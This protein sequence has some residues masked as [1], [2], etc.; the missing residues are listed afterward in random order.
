MRLRFILGDQ[1]NYNHSWLNDKCD[2]V[3]YFMCEMH[4]ETNY[5]T[6]H[7]QKVIGFFASM[8]S[9]AQFLT[10]KQHRVIYQELD[11]INSK[12]PLEEILND[13][14]TQHQITQFE[15]QFPDEYRLDQQFSNFC[16]SLNIPY[17]AYDTE[18]FY[19][20]RE[21]LT[22]FFEGKK[23]FTMEFFYR[24][25]R[26]K[27][28]VMMNDAKNPEGG[29]WNFDG[30]NRKKWTGKHIIPPNITFSKEISEIN[31]LL[32]SQGIK[33][34][35]SVNEKQF[36]WP[37]NRTESLKTLHYFCEHLLVHFGDYQD[38]MHSD[39]YYLF[40]SNLSFAMNT[41]M[42]SPKEIVDTVVSYWRAHE[43]EI[44]ISQ[45]EGFVRQIIGWREYMRGIYWMQMPTYTTLN[46]LENPNPLPS[47]YWTGKTKMNCLRSCIN[48]S[49]QTGYAHH[50]QRLMVTGN[51][52]LLTQS[53]PDQVDAW[54]LGIYSDALEW[55]QLPNTR[56]MSQYADGGIVATKPYISSGSYINK[57]SNYCKGC[58]YKVN[59]KTGEK[60]CPFNSLYWNFLH[61]KRDLL[62]NNNR[63]SMMYRLLDK[64][65]RETLT[66]HLERADHIINNP[67]EY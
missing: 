24:Y 65:D 3:V 6:H 40:H 18:H 64:M 19:T 17:K 38:A 36:T 29:K 52:A 55:V 67:N 7:I 4:Q 63:M 58:Y 30:N 26:K 10:N 48:Q 22:S 25:M 46:Q 1:L 35:G 9:Y 20:S 41:K 23:Q 61:A 50:I 44:S 15:Y 11:H 27:H 43:D 42:L 12:L 16:E 14:I 54:Y 34:I 53:H 28:Q 5:V 66:Q 49:L 59:D 13:I 37:T 56:G 51:Y 32:K 21:E 62:Q 39:Q 2:D 47:F 31:N 8:R 33:T 60:A 45:V 57:M